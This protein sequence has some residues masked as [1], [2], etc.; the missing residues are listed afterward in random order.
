MS[1]AKPD[2][3][4]TPGQLIGIVVASIVGIPVF[5]F[6]LIKVLTGGIEIDKASPQMSNEAV[7]ARIQPEGASK[8]DES[9]PPG[10]RTGKTVYENVCISCHGAGLAGA[11][12]FGDATAWS[13]SLAKGYDTLVK[14]AIKGIN[15]M[16]ARG[17]GADLTDEEV[18]RSVAYLGNAAGG[19]FTEPPVAAKPAA[20]KVEPTAPVVE[21]AKPAEVAKVEAAAPVVAA[22]I[23]PAVKGKE[24]YNTACIAC[25]G[26]GV[27]GAPKLG[28]KAAWA[29]R[30]K[31]GLDAVV[32]SAAK[33]K[34]AMPAKGGYTGSDAEFYASVEYLVNASK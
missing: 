15:G 7:V 34:G 33:G 25:H 16:P 24:I 3:P 4:M 19:K 2:N 29:P 20:A 32:A 12:K 9:G 21:A 22:K 1:E 18:A 23:D 30:L 11:P 26:A 14:N 31:G 10:S 6:F 17:G 8:L 27:A 28:D 5:I 13:A